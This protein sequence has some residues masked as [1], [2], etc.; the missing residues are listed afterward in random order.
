MLAEDDISPSSTHSLAATRPETT[1]T[2]HISKFDSSQINFDRLFRVFK[3]GSA[4][5]T[6]GAFV[7]GSLLLVLAFPPLAAVGM[8]AGSFILFATIGFSTHKNLGKIL[9]GIAT[10]AAKVA[11]G[12]SAPIQAGIAAGVAST[13]AMV[14]SQVG[15]NASY[16]A[17][18]GEQI[19]AF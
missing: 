10:Q 2:N 9:D 13:S 17:I 3:F 7:S 15:E 16:G 19:G 12:K 5:A 8:V 11:Q 14:N 1:T 18:V 6:I 4:G